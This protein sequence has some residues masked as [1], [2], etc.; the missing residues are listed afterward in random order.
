MMGDL[1]GGSDGS[2][3]EEFW[4]DCEQFAVDL[5]GA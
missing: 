3:E 5:P 2:D 4:D 1:F